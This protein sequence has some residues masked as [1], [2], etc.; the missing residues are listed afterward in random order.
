MERSQYL[1]HTVY[2]T[3][4]TEAQICPPDVLIQSGAKSE[5]FQDSYIYFVDHKIEFKLRGA[6]RETPLYC[7]VLH[8]KTFGL[9]Q[10]QHY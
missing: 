2:E 4:K 10:S 8:F 5:A 3:M 7:R 1:E 6:L 9:Q